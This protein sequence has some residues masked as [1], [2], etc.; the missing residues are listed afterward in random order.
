MKISES[1]AN[2]PS[3]PPINWA[4][5]PKPSPANI[6]NQSPLPVDHVEDPGIPSY[7]RQLLPVFISPD[8]IPDLQ[9]ALGCL[10]DPARRQ[11]RL[12]LHADSF[13]DAGNVQ[14]VFYIGPPKSRQSQQDVSNLP[15]EDQVLA[16]SL[17]RLIMSTPTRLASVTA[18]NPV[19]P[20]EPVTPTPEN[21]GL[22]P[23][24]MRTA[25]VVI[26]ATPKK[27]RYYVVLVGKCTGIYY[28]EWRVYYFF[29]V[30][31]LLTP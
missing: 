28:D 19:I 11:P 22:T 16:S 20:T 25:P 13:S 3:P 31:C 8:R 1:G 17:S 5:K 2:T 30:S 7:S 6:I 14:T 23:L 10:S 24:G 29:F 27:R 15:T 9:E 4:T 21:S 18:S 12:E 26:S